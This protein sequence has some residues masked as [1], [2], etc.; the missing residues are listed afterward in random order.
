[1]FAAFRSLSRLGHY[2][3]STPTSNS[4]RYLSLISDSNRNE[5]ADLCD[6]LNKR[7]PIATLMGMTLSF[8]L[9]GTAIVRLPYNPQLDQATHPNG[10]VFVLESTCRA[11]ESRTLN[12]IEGIRLD[13][14]YQTATHGG[15]W[16]ILADTAG[17]F[18]SRQSRP[19]GCWPLTSE[20]TMHY[21][22]VVAPTQPSR[23]GSF[24]WG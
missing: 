10:Q 9:D 15:V 18:A 23:F 11:M 7:A 20:L 8:D 1:M 13:S 19:P 6:L 4:R 21:F 2:A 16:C 17:W 3:L 22:K 24:L 14:R 5:D 12:C